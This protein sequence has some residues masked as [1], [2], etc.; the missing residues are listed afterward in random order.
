[1]F[2]LDDY[3]MDGYD[4]ASFMC[5]LDESHILGLD[6]IPMSMA[7]DP[8]RGEGHWGVRMILKGRRSRSP[9]RHKQRRQGERTAIVK[10]TLLCPLLG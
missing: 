4:V 6:D 8:E 3:S 7:D 9:W 1:M 10:R 5:Q 2:V